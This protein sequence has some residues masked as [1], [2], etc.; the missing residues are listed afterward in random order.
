VSRNSVPNVQEE[1]VKQTKEST[2]RVVESASEIEPV[3]T[4]YLDEQLALNRDRDGAEGLWLLWERRRFLVRSTV[5]GLI[6]STIVAFVIAKRYESTIRLMPP[7]AQSGS[8]MAM[9]AAMA[10]K[11]G[12]GL[13]SLAGDLLGMRGSGALF[14]DILNGRTVEDRLID[15]FDLR[16]VYHDRY[17]QD[18]RKD[19]ARHT[20]ISEDRKSGVITI[21]VTDRDPH[22]AAGLAQAYVEE[23]DR[24]VA[25]VSTSSARRE[26]VFIEQRL[27]AVKQDLDSA[28]RQFSEYASQN[29]TIDVTAQ[30]KATVEAAAQLEGEMI[31]AQSELEGLA[32]IYTKNNVRVRSLQA[33]VGELR[34]ELHKIGGDTSDQAAGKSIAPQEFPSIRQLP[35]LGVKWGDLYRETKIQETVYELL[36]QQYELAK[37]EEAKEIPVVKVLDA[38]NLPEKK[39]FPPRLFIMVLGTL[40]AIVFAATWI[41]ATTLWKSTDSQNA[42]K[43][44]VLE[45]GREA[46]EVA[47]HWGARASSTVGRL[48]KRKNGDGPGQTSIEV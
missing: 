18:A 1:I 35:L 23:L 26:R 29:T 48:Q 36:T 34:S 16:K 17:W 13:S 6:L 43:V 15:R 41:Y 27:Q 28:S 9:M 39:S 5:W 37:I 42:G 4:S 45:M 3:T 46:K 8:G 32:Q 21:A 30:T 22:R 40:L 25:Q 14:V 38:P 11:G 33:R 31:A 44:F 24:L 20:D 47:A 19:L 10:G 2:T 12:L 7:D